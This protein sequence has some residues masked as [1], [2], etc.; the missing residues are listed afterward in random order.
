MLLRQAI[1]RH[2]A[3]DVS[4][5]VA[6]YQR[7]LA[8]DP[9]NPDALHMLGVALA[10]RGAL[11][12][13]VPLMRAAAQLCLASAMMH[14]NLGNA[15][16]ALER[17]DEALQCYQRVTALEPRNG[18]AHV[19]GGIALAKLG[20]LAEAQSSFARG[21]VS[22]PRD[23]DAHYNLGNL[24][25]LERRHQQAVASFS[26]A[27]ELFPGHSD[28]RFNLALLKL[29]HGELRE[30][31]ELYEER[32][33]IDARRGAGRRLAVPRWTGKEPMA[34]RR[35]LLWAERGLGDTLQFC[36][37]AP[38]V[39]DLGAAVTLE[40]QPRLEALLAGQFAG[41]RVVRAKEPAGELDYECPLLSLPRAFGTDLTTI[42][43]QVPYLRVESASV[44]RWAQRLPPDGTLRVGIAWQGNMEA[45]RNWARGRSLPLSALEPLARR[46]GVRLVSLQT[47]PGAAELDAVNFADRIVSFGQA[48]DGEAGAFTDTAAIMM[49]LDLVISS[50]SA[51]AHLAGALGVPVWVALHATSEWRWLLD[52][53]DSPWYPTMRLFRQ[54][55]P[56]DW[57]AV[58]NELCRALSELTPARSAAQRSGADS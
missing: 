19:R 4:Q 49:S 16:S 31:W 3:G 58:V 10:Q 52:R 7:L 13:A 56:G 50:D 42:P 51:V 12:E 36:R 45:E 40:V 44:E 41:I 15:L 24:H 27:L 47:G 57:Q 22:N 28:A 21:V 1:A 26:R 34:G 29:L 18:Q 2:R 35:I 53:S 8:A 23:P 48:L 46:P 43:G 14:L 5:A 20:R 11:T 33:A 32:F 30:G 54:R 6:V 55:A 38:Q 17:Y 39:R 9:R 25:G 37:Y